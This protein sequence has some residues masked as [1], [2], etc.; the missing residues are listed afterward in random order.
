MKL[1]ERFDTP[2]LALNNSQP[3]RDIHKIAVASIRDALWKLALACALMTGAGLPGRARA[4]QTTGDESVRPIAPPSHPLPSE[5][6]SR[7]VTRFSFIVYG[8]TRGRRDGK[9]LQY[10]HSLVVD[11]ILDA[12][13]KCDTTSFPVRFVIQTGD[14]VV[15]G[16]DARQWNASFIQLV[17][18][19]TQEGGVPYYLAPGNHD[20]TTARE[21]ASPD[22]QQGLRNYLSAI[23]HLIPPD[24]TPRR[25]TGY[26]T[27]AF[28]YGNSFFIAFD[29]NIAG[30][31]AQFEWVK[32]QLESLDRNRYPLVFVFCHHPAFSSGPHGGARIEVPTREMRERYMPLFHR[33][34]VRVLLTGHEHLFEH[35]VERYTDRGKR[36][37]LDEILTGGGGAPLYPYSG[38]PDL[39]D[40]VKANED[41]KITLDHLAKPGPEAGDNPY[42]FVMVRVDGEKNSVEVRGVDWGRDFR[43]YRSSQ[44]NLEDG[45]LVGN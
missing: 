32:R 16:G 9:E 20:V 31:E 38:E 24:G 28:G 18:R 41:E 29:S 40:Y 15:N 2:R 4:Q 11:G 12:I 5:E 6:L 19:I 36:Y 17:N 1:P 42:H 34:H 7:D 39:H 37:R 35:W 8:D 23:S 30:D 26:P 21:L 44:M 13:K 10:E 27:Y 14:A 43:P 45:P 3:G 22:R 25:L 33:H